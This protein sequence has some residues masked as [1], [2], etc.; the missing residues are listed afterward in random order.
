M[1]KDVSV[2]RCLNVV[3]NKF[4]LTVLVINRAKE[5][6]LGASSEVA[7]G[8]YTKKQ[9]NKALVEIEKQI[10]DMDALREKIK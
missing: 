1:E 10:I 5:L 4:E 3:P 6:F 7:D 9:I 8:K 2:E